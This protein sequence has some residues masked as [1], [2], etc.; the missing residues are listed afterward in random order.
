MATSIRATCDLCG[1]VSFP[2]D[3]FTIRTRQGVEGGQYR[4]LCGCKRIV[5]KDASEQIIQLLRNAYVKEEIWAL[6]LELLERPN[7]EVILQEDD[8]IEL[9]LAGEDGTL[10]DRITRKFDE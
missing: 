10:Y 6:P 3:R 1:D 4:F 5:V 8:V 2:S 7:D 9:G